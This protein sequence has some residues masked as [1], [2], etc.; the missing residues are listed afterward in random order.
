MDLDFDSWISS[1]RDAMPQSGGYFRNTPSITPNRTPAIWAAF[2][3]QG[4]RLINEGYSAQKRALAGSRR[5]FERE[6][7]NVYQ[8][9]GLDQLF[10]RRQL[11]ESKPQ[12]QQQFGALEAGRLGEILDFRQGITG[13]F[14]ESN[15]AERQ[16]DIMAYNAAK[17]RSAARSGARSASRASLIGS[18]LSA[19]GSLGGGYLSGG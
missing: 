7:L 15:T 13:A 12:L 5:D 11:A 19:L 4:E 3:P 14:A 9:S 10:A 8:S 2:A 16:L 1:V 17:A 6:L 18:G